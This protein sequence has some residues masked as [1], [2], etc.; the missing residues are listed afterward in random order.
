MPDVIAPGQNASG[1]V[2]THREG[3][4]KFVRAGFVSLGQRFEFRFVIQLSSKLYAAQ[5]VDFNALL[6]AR[7]SISRACAPS[8]RHCL[9]VRLTKRVTDQVIRLTL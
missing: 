3:G 2:L 8:W 1:F 9:A 7:T 4:V 6:P 5:N